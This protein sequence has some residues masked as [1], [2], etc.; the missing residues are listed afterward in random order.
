[1]A[2]G[3]TPPA[4]HK[5]RHFWRKRPSGGTNSWISGKVAPYK[6]G[7]A[8]SS[9]ATCHAVSRLV[10]QHNRT[11]AAA[12]GFPTRLAVGTKLGLSEHET[13]ALFGWTTGDYRLIN[14]IARDVDAS[15][16]E[17]DEYPFLPQD[18]AK[19]KCQLTREDVLPYIRVMQSAL[20]KLPALQDRQRLWRGHRRHFPNT[21]PG[22][23]IKLDG[24]TSTT[25]DRDR[26]LDFAAKTNEG[27]SQK[28]TLMCI[29]Q[30]GNAKCISK[31][32]ARREEGEVLFAPGTLLVVVDPP[33]DT[34]NND[35][36]AV[37]RATQRM[38][39]VDS[40]PEAMIELIYARELIHA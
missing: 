26:A 24:F 38:R 29:L 9:A 27:R 31:L 23:I 40:M 6:G 18:T 22:T 7:S 8:T 2:R 14:P 3:A 1:M 25:R 15:V 4:Q 10:Y 34:F 39:K 11:R 12:T 17:F 13:S 32:S 21:R 28:R 35:A 20:S 37:Q 36:E 33:G 19:V 30:H 5:R 16:V